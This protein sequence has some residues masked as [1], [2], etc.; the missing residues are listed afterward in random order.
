MFYKF[1]KF[2]S[3]FVENGINIKKEIFS[4]FIRMKI[5]S[6][7]CLQYNEEQL[8]VTQNFFRQ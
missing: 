3:D 7:N 6:C 1:N 4:Y 8:H 5:C 2:S